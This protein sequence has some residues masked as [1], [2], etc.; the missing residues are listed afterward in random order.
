MQVKWG[1]VGTGKICQ[2]FCL[3]LLT[4]DSREHLIVAVGSREKIKADE[5]VKRFNLGNEVRTYASQEEVFQDSNVDIVYIGTM[6]RY[7]RDLCIKALN[8]DKH[9]LCEKPLAMN[10]G[11]V[12]EIIDA[13]RKTKKFMMEAIWSRFFPIYDSLRE[14]VKQIG[15]VDL[16][17]AID[18][19]LN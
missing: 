1:I 16:R 12:E 15:K 4:C 14:A 10:T 11:E 19:F 9:V 5:F 17:K 2:D 13:A 3:A 6:E 18:Y 7:H 8:Q